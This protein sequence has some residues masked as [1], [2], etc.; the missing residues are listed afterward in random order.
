MQKGRDE[1][2]VTQRSRQKGGVC[3]DLLT[4]TP[5]NKRKTKEKSFSIHKC[6]YIEVT[7]VDK[8]ISKDNNEEK[9][10]VAILSKK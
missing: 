9:T 5:H 10:E 6:K 2:I 1:M 8:W 4:I 7:I 3:D